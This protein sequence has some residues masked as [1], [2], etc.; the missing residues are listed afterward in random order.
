MIAR[1][2]K[3]PPNMVRHTNL[4]FYF[5]LLIPLQCRGQTAAS[6]DTVSLSLPDQTW[7]LEVADP[8]F[9]VQWREVLPENRGVHLMAAGAAM[10]LSLQLEKRTDLNSSKAFRDYHLQD[11]RRMLGQ[12]PDLKLSESETWAMTDTPAKLFHSFTAGTPLGT[13]AE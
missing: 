11:L 4:S 3:T 12:L 13:P 6:R 7:S 2:V 5:L 1:M 10:G 8:R 9:T